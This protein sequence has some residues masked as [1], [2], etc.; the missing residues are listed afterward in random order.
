MR[1]PALGAL[2]VALLAA[3]AT[4]PAPSPPPGACTDELAP[5]T[6][7]TD[8][9]LAVLYA[10]GDDVPPVVGE[11]EWLAGDEPV[12]TDA[13]RPVHL[14]RFTVLQI[15][16]QSEIS[17]RMSDGVGIEAWTVDAVPDD[18]FRAGNLDTGRIRW[19][20]GS[21]PTNVVCLPVADGNWAVVAEITFAD[22]A[23]GGT[24]YWRLNVSDVPG[25]G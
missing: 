13:A 2:L 15:Q 20:E 17:L 23:G 6:S 3:C 4:D 10:A 24:Y 1:G 21:G 14:E 22:G 16:A 18:E 5:R 7:P 25:G 11:V 12:A 9:P 8:Y 19:S